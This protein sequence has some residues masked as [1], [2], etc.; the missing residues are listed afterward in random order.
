MTTHMPFPDFPTLLPL[1]IIF[2]TF[3][4]VLSVILISK[5]PK[6]GACL[7]AGLILAALI[8]L[9]HGA[10]GGLFSTPAGLPFAII[11]GTF[12]FILV[13]IVLAK[14]PKAGVVLVVG[15]LGLGLFGTVFAMRISR[16]RAVGVQQSQVFSGARAT[17]SP[18]PNYIMTDDEITQ[19]TR[20]AELRRS[21]PPASAPSQASATPAPIWSAGVDEELE[22][23]VYPS[24]LAAA[25]AAGTQLGKP[26]RELSPDVNAPAHVVIFQEAHEYRLIAELRDAVRRALPDVSCDVEAQSRTLKPEEL[27]VTLY[28]GESDVRSAPWA[29]S[30][31]I[32]VSR[33]E[34][35]VQFQ[36]AQLAETTMV[37]SGQLD[38]NVS[39]RGGKVHLPVRFTEKPWM[40]DFATFASTRPQRAFIIARSVGTCTSESEAN[41]QALDDARARLTEAIGSHGGRKLGPSAPAIT[42]TDVLQGGFIVDRFAQSLEGSVGRIWRQALLI[43]VSGPKLAQLSKVKVV[44]YRQVRES[45]ARMAL[46]AVGVIVLIGVIYFFLNMATRGYYEW[47]L[48]IAG[49]VLAIV[50]VISIL[51]VVR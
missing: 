14:D 20:T 16:P 47:S 39:G 49:V 51:M 22:A 36:P 10:R 31:E 9:L 29:K 40:D 4:F 7:V 33:G 1:V 17:P 28:I 11:P 27:G 18:V 13:V 48:R 26:I 34:G 35:L 44:E 50:A 19:Q 24:K 38:V 2:A 21:N 25:R 41:Q 12:L 8:L 6:A 15:L 5:S 42:T 30:G 37:A 45:Y 3:A 23:D 46:S 32:A 43:D